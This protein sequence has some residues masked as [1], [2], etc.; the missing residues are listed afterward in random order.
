ME[1]SFKPIIRIADFNDSI[2]A[3]Q[4]ASEINTSVKQRGVN[5]AERGAA[6]IIGKMVEGNSILAFHPMTGEW[7]G[8]C[9]LEIWEKQKYVTNTCLIVAPKYRSHGVSKFLKNELFELCKRKYSDYK[10]MSFTTS[11]AVISVNID[12]G[13]KKLSYADILDQLPFLLNEDS[14]VNYYDLIHNNHLPHPYIMMVYN[15]YEV[16]MEFSSSEMIRQAI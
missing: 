5:V 8:F 7:M 9:T 11:P 3:E 6:Y 14:H 16:S 4:I 2:Y 13:F 10:I 15:P 1:T 12:L